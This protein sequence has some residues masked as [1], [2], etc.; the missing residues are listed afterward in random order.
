MYRHRVATYIDSVAGDSLRGVQNR[1][2][3]RTDRPAGGHVHQGCAHWQ[4]RRWSSHTSRCTRTGCRWQ[5]AVPPIT[6]AMPPV[7]T[8]RRPVSPYTVGDPL[9]MVPGGTRHIPDRQRTGRCP[10]RRARR[11][12]QQGR[13]QQEVSHRQTSGPAR[14]VRSDCVVLVDG[15]RIELPTSALRTQRSPS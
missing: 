12:L 9:Y 11:R 6:S 5:R 7:Y 1:W 10:A 4:S 14:K 13:L 8:G 2:S 3:D 15:G